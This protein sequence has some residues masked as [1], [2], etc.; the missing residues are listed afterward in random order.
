MIAL[1]MRPN[2]AA[3]A[4]L[5]MTAVFMSVG[6]LWALQAPRLGGPS[7]VDTLQAQD[8][9]NRLGLKAGLMSQ[10]RFTPTHSWAVTRP[11]PIGERIKR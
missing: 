7:A 3:T 9:S 4:Q 8:A 6:V 1:R 11:S 5:G 10:T 2:T